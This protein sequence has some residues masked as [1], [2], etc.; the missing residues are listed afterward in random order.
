MDRI[1]LRLNPT[2]Y[3]RITRGMN[4]EKPLAPQ[5]VDKLLKAD[6]PDAFAKHLTDLGRI[7]HK[8]NDGWDQ[9]IALLKIL[10]DDVQ[11]LKAAHKHNVDQLE[12]VAKDAARTKLV[13]ENIQD[14]L[15]QE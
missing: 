1:Y 15:A 6:E 9:V 2:Q 4:L 12:A 8:I 10:V 11:K 14:Y 5:I 7:E 13:V 3:K